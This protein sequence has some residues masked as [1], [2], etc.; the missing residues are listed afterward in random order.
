MPS[1]EAKQGKVSNLA[2]HIPER[3]LKRPVAGI[4]ECQGSKHIT[5]PLDLAHLLPD[6]QV[7][8]LFKAVHRI[9]RP[10]AHHPRVGMHLD[11]GSRKACSHLVIP[12][13]SERWLQGN[14]KVPNANIRDANSHFSPLEC[15][16]S[17]LN[18]FI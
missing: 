5:V 17:D 3:D 9:A 1:P 8:E 7:L 14:R 11:N 4:V 10:V 2:K 16:F 13:G 6:E 12:R 15:F 18:R